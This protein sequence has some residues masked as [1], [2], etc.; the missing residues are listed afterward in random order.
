LSIIYQ[1]HG[2]KRH[3]STASSFPNRPAGKV[4]QSHPDETRKRHETYQYFL[5]LLTSNIYLKLENLQPSG[6]FKSRGI[7]NLMVRAS[8]A[9]QCRGEDVRFYCSSGGNA[10][11]ACITAAA[12]LG[13]AVVVAVPLTTPAFMVGKLTA[14]GAEVHQVGGDW[15]AADRFLRERLLAADP[16]G[17]YVPPFD[18]PDIWDG[19]ASLVDELARQVPG[20]DAVVCSVGGGGLLNG[21]MQ[22][23]ARNSWG[24]GGGGNV[25]RVL[26]VETRGAD[27]LNLCAR[28]GTHAA[29]PGITS[30]ATSLGATKVSE[31]SFRWLRESRHLSSLVVEDC[32][33]ATS[34]VRFADDARVIVEPACGATLAV[35][36]FP[37]AAG[38]RD[39]VRDASSKKEW[40]DYNVVLVVCGGSATTL[41][42]LGKY[43]TEFAVGAKMAS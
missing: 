16:A 23:V 27:S 20:P 26:A 8:T 35:A 28:T 11:L 37:E 33:A 24:A 19:A 2:S 40:R 6:S 31:R 22:G 34:C 9:A 4:H 1:N 18:H 12:A 13:R 30:I 10:G 29:L 42:M 3:A 14:R 15:P 21:V 41:D 7:G 43:R 17:V 36:Y 32:H 5:F 38:L 25:P 39:R